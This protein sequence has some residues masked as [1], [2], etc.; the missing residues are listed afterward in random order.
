MGRSIPERTFIEAMTKSA[1]P[2]CDSLALANSS[3][4]GMAGGRLVD[5]FTNERPPNL[6][7]FVHDALRALVLN[8]HFTC[9]G[10]KAAVRQ[11]QYRFGLY[12]E[13]G[14]AGAV[15]GLARDLTEFVADLAVHD[16]LFS[17][18]LASFIGPNP[19]DEPAFES[20]LWRLL[21]QL[22]DLDAPHHR[23]DPAVDADPDSP[24]FAFSFAGTAFFVIG[25]HAGS[26]RAARRFAW[27][28]L[29]FNPHRQFEE[30]RHNGRYTRFQEVIRRAETE[31]QGTVNPMLGAH[32][33]VSQAAQYSGRRVEDGW[34]CPF[35]S[36]NS[37]SH[38][39]ERQNQPSG[40]DDIAAVAAIEAAA[41]EEVPAGDAEGRRMAG[42]PLP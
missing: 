24:D 2:F 19:A 16:G 18:Y 20:L 17:T 12:D 3:Y 30:L 8:D 6:T 1:N 29:V 39:A 31:L 21:Q 41:S 27:P 7:V 28:T 33:S 32:G 34:H 11:Q 38:E 23:W 26:S 15:A 36:R 22:H 5:L 10:G 4:T 40:G 37:S 14:S 35:H 25:L 9:H 13:L 42:I